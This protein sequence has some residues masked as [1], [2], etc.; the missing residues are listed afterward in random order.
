[1]KLQSGVINCVPIDFNS[2]SKEYL[3]T[4]SSQN[5]QQIHQKVE[6]IFINHPDKHKNIIVEVKGPR[7][8][9]KF[10]RPKRYNAFTVDMYL[11]V[12]QAVNSAQTR[13]DIKFIVLMGEGGN[14]SSGND[15]SNF[16]HPLIMELGDFADV[17]KASSIV[18]HNL[19]IAFI[20]SKKPII[21]LTEGKVIGFAFTKLALFDKVFSVQNSQFVAPLVSSGQGP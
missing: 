7:M 13:D 1:M 8:T 12:T 19:T 18:L 9:V 11:T 3:M 21:A 17:I 16:T 14:F 20:N 15:L 6:E 5:A 10:N 2:L 4:S